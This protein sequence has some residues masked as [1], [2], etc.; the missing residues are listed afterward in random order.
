MSPDEAAQ[1]ESHVVIKPDDLEARWLLLGHYFRRQ[2]QFPAERPARTRHV[3]WV[4]ANAPGSDLASSSL[5]GLYSIIDPDA[6]AEARSLWLRQIE[7]E[8]AD[9]EVLGNAA[10]FF[11]LE[12]AVLCADL[13]RRCREVKPHQPRWPARLA[14][15]LQ[16]HGR[17]AANP[18]ERLAA[19][20]EALAEFEQ[21]WRLTKGEQGRFALLRELATT[22]LHGGEFAKAR[23]YA[24]ELLAGAGRPELADYAGQAVYYGNMVLGH[25]ALVGSEVGKAKQHLVEAGRTP[26]S[27]SLDSFGPKMQLAKALLERGE[28]ETVLEYLRLC[29]RFWKPPDQRLDKWIHTVEQGGIPDFGANLVY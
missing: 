8:D 25:L 18:S 26:G 11:D 1:F 16:R 4:I 21:A 10:T 19:A 2:R 20:T 17:H 7:A 13:L 29:S 24:E 9:A 27:P 12:D 15:H 28:R 14:R 3:L 23:R 22:A 6:Y 5:C